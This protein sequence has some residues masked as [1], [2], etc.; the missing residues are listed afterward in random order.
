MKFRFCSIWILELMPVLFIYFFLRRKRKKSSSKLRCKIATLYKRPDKL[1]L[2]ANFFFA[3]LIV[4]LQTAL[5][6]LY[7]A[8][9]LIAIVITMLIRLTIVSLDMLLLKN[10]LHILIC[11]NFMEKK[12]LFFSWSSCFWIFEVFMVL[13]SVGNVFLYCYEVQWFSNRWKHIANSSDI[14]SVDKTGL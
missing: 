12:T 9:N 8:S 5:R 6:I 4:I 7:S 3:M 10:H 2:N 1:L 14:S 13:A 11:D